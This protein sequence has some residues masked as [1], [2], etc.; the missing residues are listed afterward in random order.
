M[1][2]TNELTKMLFYIKNEHSVT[3]RRFTLTV[4]KKNTPFS[5][6]I[7][8]IPPNRSLQEY[9]ALLVTKLYT[10]TFPQ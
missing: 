10:C 5:N 3:S 7:L 4:T 9:G 2:Y 1:G 8:L 6:H